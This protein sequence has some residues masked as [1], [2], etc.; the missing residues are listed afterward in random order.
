MF[1]SEHQDSDFTTADESNNSTAA[2]QQEELD[3]LVS[4][5]SN[6]TRNPSVSSQD[7]SYKEINFIGLVNHYCQKKTLCH[8]FVEVKRSGPAHIPQFFYKLVIDNKDYPVAEGKTAKEAK[9]NAAHLA[10]TAL[11]EQTD[12]DSKCSFWDRCSCYVPVACLL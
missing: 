3:Q 2:Q 6:K 1:G 11:Q 10:W 12:W 8:T 9:Q 7:N 5:T 4:K